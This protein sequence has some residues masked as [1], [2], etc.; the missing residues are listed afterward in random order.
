MAKRVIAFVGDLH[1]GSR[2]AIAPAGYRTQEDNAIHINEGQMTL[3]KHWDD[4]VEKCDEMQVDTVFLMGDLVDGPNYKGYA[5]HLI[6]SDLGDQIGMAVML[7]RRLC[8]GRKVYG[9]EGSK[10]HVLPG[11]LSADQMVVQQLGGVWCGPILVGRFQ[12]CRLT[13]LIQHGEGGALLYRATEPD[14]E[15]LHLNAAH[16]TGKI[17]KIDVSVKGHRHYHLYL[18]ENG[19]HQ[20]RVPCWCAFM[21]NRV[22]LKN[23][24]R[25]QPDV[26]GVILELEENRLIHHVF[27]YDLPHIADEVR[28]L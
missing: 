5:R 3:L 17:E 23:Y 14:K 25:M 24:G 13:F 20:I 16:G 22:Y 15:N 7:L 21:P 19:Q 11:G 2:Y 12:P 9:V 4:F 28:V 10:Y 1:V 27:L 6:T 18:V 26:G 8:E